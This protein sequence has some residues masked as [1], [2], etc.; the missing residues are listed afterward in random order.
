MLSRV[1]GHSAATGRSI[2]K[3]SDLTSD[4]IRRFC[5]KLIHFTK[6]LRRYRSMTLKSGEVV[7]NESGVL[8][9]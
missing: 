9:K 7:I 8:D 6:A 4:S 2:V 1:D 3:V 5:P